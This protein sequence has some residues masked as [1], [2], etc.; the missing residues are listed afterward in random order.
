[1]FSFK[2][3]ATIDIHGMTVR[4]AEVELTKRISLLPDDIEQ[5]VVVHGFNRG[6]ALM[7]FVRNEF[8]HPRIYKISFTDNYGE[9]VLE[10]I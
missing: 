7:N 1:M 9:T 6:N 4:Q 3:R 5:V 2:K 10:L 8:R